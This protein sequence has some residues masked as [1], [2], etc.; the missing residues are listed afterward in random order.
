[1][2]K[3]VVQTE[4]EITLSAEIFDFYGTNAQSFLSDKIGNSVYGQ[5]LVR[6][7]P[8]VVWIGV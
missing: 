2:D 4:E 8:I 1:M 7:S 6:H 3:L 5:E